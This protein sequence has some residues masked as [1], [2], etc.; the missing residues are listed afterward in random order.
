VGN[1][2][3]S[4]LERE[5]KEMLTPFSFFREEHMESKLRRIAILK[6]SKATTIC[7]ELGEN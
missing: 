6:I 7:T 2:K 5:N 3:Q 1:A 4:G